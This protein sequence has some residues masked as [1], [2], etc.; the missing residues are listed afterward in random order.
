[1]RHVG[2]HPFRRTHACGHTWLML[3]DPC[4]VP[5]RVRTPLRSRGRLHMSHAGLSRC[6][7]LRLWLPN[8]RSVGGPVYATF[9]GD[10]GLL[11]EITRDYA[12]PQMRNL[13]A[14]GAQIALRSCATHAPNCALMLA[15][16]CCTEVCWNP[17]ALCILRAIHIP[18]SGVPCLVNS[19]TGTG[20]SQ[21]PIPTDTNLTMWPC[22][23]KF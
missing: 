12:L 15:H 17:N 10:P 9:Q 8:V 22:S 14:A 1:M 5:W 7:P 19:R 18:N 20:R 4:L 3:H 23:D 13:R 2:R 6:P 21:R 16:F 11:L